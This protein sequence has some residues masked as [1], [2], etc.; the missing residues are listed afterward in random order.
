MARIGESTSPLASP[1]GS[2]TPCESVL[3]GIERLIVELADAMVAAPAN[4]PDELY[5]KSPLRVTARAQ[6]PL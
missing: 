2:T 6:S 1:L 4:V 5:A 3:T